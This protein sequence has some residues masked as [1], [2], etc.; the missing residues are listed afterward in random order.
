MWIKIRG[1]PFHIFMGGLEENMYTEV[2][3]WLLRIVCFVE[4]SPARPIFF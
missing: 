1:P 3:N 2:T 4:D